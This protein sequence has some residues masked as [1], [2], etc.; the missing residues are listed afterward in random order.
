M[1]STYKA[2]FFKYVFKRIAE[3]MFNMP[4]PRLLGFVTKKERAAAVMIWVRL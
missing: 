1:F 4:Q 3:E 2:L